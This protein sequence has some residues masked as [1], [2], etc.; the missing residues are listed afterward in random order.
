MQMKVRKPNLAT[1]ARWL[2]LNDGHLKDRVMKRILL[3]GMAV[4]GIFGCTAHEIKTEN[5]EYEY[6]VA[7]EE[8]SADSLSIGFS[9]EWPAGGLPSVA[10]ENIRIHI[11]GII[12]GKNM[13]T[14]DI[15]AAMNEFTKKEITLYRNS[16]ND[17]RMMMSSYDEGMKFSWTEET[18][19]CF[20]EPYRNMQ[21]YLIYNYTFTGGAHGMDSERGLTFDLSSGRAV[22]E[23][24]LFKRYYK[25]TLSKLLSEK[26]KESMD[27]EAYEMLFI[28]DIE[29]NGNFYLDDKGITYIYGRYE[30]GPYVSGLVRVSVPWSELKDILK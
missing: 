19:G 15:N 21:S 30:I 3:W 28:K 27:E 5:I 7:L 13:A 12:F 11:T 25:P 18:E 4:L 24:D 1:W 29:P 17:F 20:L 16:I 8:G 9:L 26:L 2:L 10:M 6:S 14:A 22:T 23:A